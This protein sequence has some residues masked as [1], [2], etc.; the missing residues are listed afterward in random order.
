MEHIGAL[1]KGNDSATTTVWLQQ[2]DDEYYG[3]RPAPQR[4]G[5]HP[6]GSALSSTSTGFGCCRKSHGAEQPAL[7][8]LPH[9]PLR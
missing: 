7:A 8:V 9:R 5:R 4:E 6:S 2:V 3:N 1:E